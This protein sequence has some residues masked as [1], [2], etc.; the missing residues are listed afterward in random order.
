M[1]EPEWTRVLVV[2]ARDGATL[3]PLLRQGW[4][5]DRLESRSRAKKSVADGGHVAVI[6]H[7]TV[8]E[9]RTRLTENDRANGFANRHLLALVRRSRLLPTGGTMDEAVIA[10]FGRRTRDA[11][12]KARKVGIVGRTARAEDLWDG[13]Y[14]EMADDEPGGLLGAIIARD[15]AQVLRLSVAYALTDG[16]HLIDVAHL[17]AAWAVWR[18]CR[19]SAEMIFGDVAGIPVVDRILTAVRGVGDAGLTYDE[20]RREDGG[21]PVPALGAGRRRRTSRHLRHGIVIPRPNWRRGSPS[22]TKAW[23]CPWASGSVPGGWR[24]RRPTSGTRGPATW[25]CA[26]AMPRVWRPSP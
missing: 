9:L 2:S 19:L 10:D 16:S 11:L 1:I 15:Q 12:L 23:D 14:R 5:G 25:T 6:G 17:E 18:Y 13:L 20:L 21:R 22:L 3:S 7:V 26:Y 24:I 8:D 4:D